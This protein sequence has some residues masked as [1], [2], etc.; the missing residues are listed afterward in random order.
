MFSVPPTAKIAPIKGILPFPAPSLSLLLSNLIDQPTS[1]WAHPSILCF[2]TPTLDLPLCNPVPQ[3]WCTL[4]AT[5]QI[6]PEEEGDPKSPAQRS[7][8]GGSTPHPG[9]NPDSLALPHPQLPLTP[10]SSPT[11]HTISPGTIQWV[12]SVGVGWCRQRHLHCSLPQ[13]TS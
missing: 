9:S 6:L 10:H 13:H 3:S 11:H 2:P 8:W 12:L 1:F 5:N 4:G 7:A